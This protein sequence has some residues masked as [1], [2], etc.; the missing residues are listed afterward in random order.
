MPLRIGNLYTQI[1][2]ALTLT[3][4]AKNVFR[5]DSALSDIINTVRNRVRFYYVTVVYK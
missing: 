5:I 2:H 4:N 1:R 3:R